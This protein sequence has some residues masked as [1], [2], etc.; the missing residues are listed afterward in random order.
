MN[1]DRLKQFLIQLSTSGGGVKPK[2]LK[3]RLYRALYYAATNEGKYLKDLFPTINAD[4]VSQMKDYNDPIKNARVIEKPFYSTK[5]NSDTYSHPRGKACA[6]RM[7]KGEPSYRCE[8]CG[9]DDTCVLCVYC[10]NK[11]DHINHD[12]TMYLSD[13]KSG[14]CDCGDIEAFKSLN[15]KCHSSSSSSSNTNNQEIDINGLEDSLLST[16]RIALDYI[17]DVTNFAIH[18]LP[19]IHSRID[20]NHIEL[21]RQDISEFSNLPRENYGGIIDSHYDEDWYL[22]LWNDERHNA[23]EAKSSIESG[24]GGTDK[25]LEDLTHTIDANG[26]CIIEQSKNLSRL[27][28]IKEKVEQG[29][30]VASIIRSRDYTRDIMVEFIIQ[31]L[32]DIIQS[33]NSNFSELC[34]SIIAEL[35]LEPDYKLA[36]PWPSYMFNNCGPNFEIEAFQNGFLMDNEF[37]NLGYC[38]VK[39]TF[40]PQDIT[41]PFRIGLTHKSELNKIHQSRLQYLLLFEIRLAKQTRKKL[42]SLFLQPIVSDLDKKAIFAYQLMEIFPSLL[43]ILAIADREEDLNSLHEIAVQILTC[44]TCVGQVYANDQLGNVLGP[45]V[46]LIES[47]SIE[48]NIDT[49]YPNYINI[50]YHGLRMP[51]KDALAI[52]KAIMFGIWTIKKLTDKSFAGDSIVNI[53]NPHNLS[54]ILMLLRYFQGYWPMIRKYGEH[55]ETESYD[56][57]IHLEFSRQILEIVRSIALYNYDISLVQSALQLIIEC[58]YLRPV[59]YNDKGLIEFKVS[60]DSVAFVNPINSLLSYMLQFRGITDLQMDKFTTQLPQICDLSLTSIVLGFQIKIGFWIRNGISASRQA[61]LYFDPILS[62]HTYL[63]DFYLCQVNAIYNDPTAVFHFFLHRWELNNW[64][65]GIEAHDKTGYEDRFNSISEKMIIFFY[66]LITDRSSFVKSS[67]EERLV[68][69]AKL[70]ISYALCDE[71]RSYSNLRKRVGDEINSLPQYDTILKEVADY[72]EPSGLV[73]TGLYRLKA[74]QFE[75]LDPLSLLLDSNKFQQVSETLIKNVAKINKIPEDSVVLMPRISPSDESFINK[76][77]ANFTKTKDFAKLIYKYLQLSIDSSDETY[78]PQLLHLVHAVIKDD[79]LLYGNNYLNDHFIT[80]PI[81][82]LLLT[83]VESTMSKYVVSKADYLVDQFISKDSRIMENLIDCFGE[84]YIKT[85]K[86]KKTQETEI[87]KKKRIAEDRKAKIMKKFAKKRSKFLQQ[88]PSETHDETSQL[89]HTHLENSSNVSFRTC[90]LCGEIENTKDPFG[91]LYTSAETATLWKVPDTT[92]GL[93]KSLELWQP[94][95]CQLDISTIYGQGYNYQQEPSQFNNV[96]FRANVLT[97]C[98]HGMHYSCYIRS[99]Q[100]LRLFA[101]PLCHNLHEKFLPSFIPPNDGGGLSLEEIFRDTKKVKYNQILRSSSN[102]KCRKLIEAT[103]HEDY[104]TSNDTDF[105]KFARILSDDLSYLPT[106]RKYLVG[107]NNNEKYFNSLQNVSVMIGDIIRMSEI[108]TRISGT[109]SYSN[110]LTQIS[111]PTKILLRSLIQCRAVMFECR[112]SPILLNTNYGLDFEINSFWSSDNLLDGVFNEV[113]SLFFQTD[114]SLVTLCRLGITK[115]L[116]ICIYSLFDRSRF[117]PDLIDIL[118]D[119]EDSPINEDTLKALAHLITYSVYEMPTVIISSSDPIVR[120]YY[121]TIERLVLPLLRQ[122]VIL[123]DIITAKHV[124]ENTFESLDRFQDLEFDIMAQKRPA[125]SDALTKV[126][127]LPSLSELIIGIAQENGDERFE[128]ESQVYDI[129]CN[130]KIPKYYEEGILT[131]EYPGVVQLIPMTKDYNA[132]V[133]DSNNYS[134]KGGY[135]K[136]VCL[137]C[138][139]R[140]KSSRGAQHLSE[141]SVHT[142]PFFIPRLNVLRIITHSGPNRINVDIS[143]PYLTSHGEVKKANTSGNASLNKQRYLTLNKLWLNH[144]LNSFVSRN[145]YDSRGDGN[146]I[147]IYVQADDDWE[148]EG[149]GEEEEEEEDDDSGEEF[150]DVPVNNFLW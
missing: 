39:S 77:I 53:L 106:V 32:L 48:W 94:P 41:K 133:I 91:I 13:G 22:I 123:E 68:Q 129:V 118:V 10:F 54:M 57:T 14:I 103:I 3:F 83:I 76:S 139:T 64:F 116:T 62:E 21:N 5:E 148:D 2:E 65:E 81:T 67:T 34:K 1:E 144:G 23:P 135:D 95:N 69:K 136:M 9:Y 18:T 80:I 87:D 107:I 86:R 11:D 75:Q 143:G 43:P 70:A 84:E 44:P 147:N 27:I 101:C 100:N 63:R 82:D 115:L 126:L 130:A 38:Q 8:Q 20:N 110:F 146:I 97:T 109:V 56:F 113:V 4:E 40:E 120:K 142:G 58:L 90:V 72:Q 121:F 47:Y 42:P 89:E 114:E 92:Q 119:E 93:A 74:S 30:L 134:I 33:T 149:E 88:N 61:S 12:V 35:L 19:C 6:R 96:S 24:I 124:S 112:S 46:S 150:G 137:V 111:N 105:R 71:P 37:P 60:K 51:Y 127:G 78:L 125:C 50:D 140:V 79:E 104:I 108:S 26:R 7:K 31:W 102:S 85:Y 141:C 49:V 131:L 36:K 138:G 99:S 55:V 52:K 29:G 45:L 122:L 59:S 25:Q 15:C 117:K 132:C 66:N 28:K 17:L 145:I 98:G 73:D 16:I 128:F